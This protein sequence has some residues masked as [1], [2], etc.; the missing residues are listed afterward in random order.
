[1]NKIK[2]IYYLTEKRI[3]FYLDE[4]KDIRNN[5]INRLNTANER[6]LFNNRFIINIGKLILLTTML[7]IAMFTVYDYTLGIPPLLSAFTLLSFQ[8]TL[9]YFFR[10][11][12]I[13]ENRIFSTRRI[14]E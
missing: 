1:M 11:M 12:K 8:T 13:K 14:E 5:F 7:I 2:E 6:P 9:F 10:E 4:Y 3:G